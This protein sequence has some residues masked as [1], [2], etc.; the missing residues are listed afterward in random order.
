MNAAN[1]GFST[2]TI[3]ATLKQEKETVVYSAETSTQTVMQKPAP[4]VRKST[5]VCTKGKTVKKVVGVKP[6]C[7][8][9]FTKKR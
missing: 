1:F 2:P 8:K 5:I 9:G 4:I 7:P 3:K 6:V